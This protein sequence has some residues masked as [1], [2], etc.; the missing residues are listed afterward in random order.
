MLRMIKRKFI[1]ILLAVLFSSIAMAQNEKYTSNETANTLYEIPPIQLINNPTAGT[2]PRGCFNVS[3]RLYGN[4]GLLWNTTI[5]LSSRFQI[6]VS[7]GAEG[8]I[9]DQ[10]IQENPRI[11]FNTKLRLID[12]S[13]VLPAFAVGF[14]SQGFGRYID[15]EERYTFKS[16]GFYGVVSRSLVLGSVAFGGHVGMNYSLEHSIDGD[17]E[18][19]IFMGIDTRFAYNIGFSIEYEIALNDDSNP[20][21]NGRGYLNL[22]VKWMY[23]EN[24]EFEFILNDML[25]NRKDFGEETYSIGRELRFTYIEFF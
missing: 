19:P 12:E 24:L 7:Y 5:G 3:M 11:E 25:G 1:I 16:K 13:Y 22:S 17:K 21:S 15:D 14:N 2:L 23:S 18:P 10:D 6:G 8:L 4:G 9:S 20:Y